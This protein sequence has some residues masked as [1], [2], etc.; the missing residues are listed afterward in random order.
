MCVFI[1]YPLERTNELYKSKLDLSVFYLTDV[2]DKIDIA[3]MN[4]YF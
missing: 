3:N 2:V 1:D 4:L